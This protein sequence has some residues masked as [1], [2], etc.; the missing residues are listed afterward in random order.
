MVETFN[1]APS[2][3]FADTQGKDGKLIAAPGEAQPEE[4]NLAT[5]DPSETLLESGQ[6]VIPKGSA[7]AVQP[8]AQA[9]KEEAA[10]EVSSGMSLTD[11]GL[12]G[13][14]FVAGAIG[15]HYGINRQFLSS[16]G[17]GIETMKTQAFGVADLTPYA[18]VA[19]QNID[20]LGAEMAS[21][22]TGTLRLGGERIL[23]TGKVAMDRDATLVAAFKGPLDPV[24]A[25]S[26]YGDAAQFLRTDIGVHSVTK[27]VGRGPIR[28]FDISQEANSALGPAFAQTTL[29]DGNKFAKFTSDGVLEGRGLFTEAQMKAAIEQGQ[30][31]TEKLYRS[32]LRTEV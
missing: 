27:T 31:T 18:R 3:K 8:V 24:N 9:A 10:A 23:S 17:R 25:I 5:Q 11:V 20:T 30:A 21:N 4:Q 2:A 1:P 15:Q 6:T 19:A 12:L 13:G 28:G 16:L 14:A 26:R 7:D 32:V 22:L 29:R